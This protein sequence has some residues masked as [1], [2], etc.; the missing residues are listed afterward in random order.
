MASGVPLFCFEGPDASK[1]DLEFEPSPCLAGGKIKR[2]GE[3]LK[4]YIVMTPL[5]S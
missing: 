4:G 5:K 2:S 3:S 1:G